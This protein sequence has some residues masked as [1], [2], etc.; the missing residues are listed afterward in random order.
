MNKRR[1][2]ARILLC[3][4]VVL[5]S[6]CTSSQTRR[7]AAE[8]CNEYAAHPQDPNRLI[9]Q[10]VEDENIAARAAI[11]ACENAV[12]YSPDDATYIFQLGR[13]YLAARRMEEAA[14]Q[15]DKAAELEYGPAF[16][17]LGDRIVEQN[18]EQ[19]KAYYEKARDLGFA[20]AGAPLEHV[21]Q[22]LKSTKFNP[23]LFADETM[24]HLYARDYD[25]IDPLEGHLYVAS[26]LD[27]LTSSQVLLLDATCKPLVSTLEHRIKMPIASFVAWT[28]N[29]LALLAD[30]PE[31]RWKN[32]GRIAV[33]W[34]LREPIAEQAEKDA[35][36]LVHQY[37]CS[38]P[39]T[40]TAYTNATEYL[41]LLLKL[42]QTDEEPHTRLDLE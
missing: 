26:L 19:A 2:S 42:K 39:V 7:T 37:T 29:A 6:A 3:A 32:L 36:V 20:P 31:H 1:Q 24:A 17:Y 5:L 41:T 28:K 14:A 27:T 40:K 15:F 23:A 22:Y 10:G 4:G 38:G 30:D 35:L 21:E 13:A 9:K 25:A 8:Q 11:E 16:K 34:W 33:I 12:Y 18:P